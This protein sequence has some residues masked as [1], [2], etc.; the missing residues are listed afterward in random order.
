[1]GDGRRAVVVREHRA[2]GAGRGD[3]T[4]RHEH[5]AVGERRG[6]FE[7]VL[8]EHDRRAEIGVEPGQR[9]EHVVG[10]LRVELRGRFVEH[11]HRGRRGQRARDRAALPF[12]ARERRRRA[13]AQVGDR[14]RVEHLLD[15]A[16]HRLRRYRGSRARTRGRSRR[17]RRRTAPRGPGARSRRDRRARAAGACGSSGHR[18]EPNRRTV[19]P[20]SAERARSRS[21]AACS[22]PSPSLR[23]RGRARPRRSRDRCRCSA[24]GPSGYAKPVPS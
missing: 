7:P 6:P 15:P 2:R 9:G 23:S 16:P 22:C 18:R 17:G 24:T 21:A 19:R 10:A 14:E 5:R 11:E 13:V 8:G 3:R 20:T 4:A 12:A 1:M